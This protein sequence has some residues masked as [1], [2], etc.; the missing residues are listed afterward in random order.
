MRL[1]YSHH[2]L[3]LDLMKVLFN[4][5]GGRGRAPRISRVFISPRSLVRRLLAQLIFLFFAVAEKIS[6]NQHNIDGSEL[7]FH[8]LV[9]T[10]PVK[11]I[12]VGQTLQRYLHYAYTSFIGYN[13]VM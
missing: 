5:V 3:F 9:C 2:D 7:K 1:F 11:V 4:R 8:P 12:Q 6:E 10:D 13:Y